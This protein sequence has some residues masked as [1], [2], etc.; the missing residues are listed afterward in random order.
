MMNSPSVRAPASVV[1]AGN[2]REDEMQK[3]PN[4]TPGRIAGADRVSMAPGAGAGAEAFD[5]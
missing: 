2:A 5:F 3:A 4:G 1:V